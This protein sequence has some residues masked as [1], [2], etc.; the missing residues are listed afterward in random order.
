LVFKNIVT[1]LLIIGF[2]AGCA[3]NT[4]L[5]KK[6]NSI[7]LWYL[8]TPIN[9]SQFIYGTGTALTIDDAKANG[10]NDM[11]SRLVVSVGSTISSITKTSQDNSSSSYSKNVSKNIKVDIEKIKFSNAITE[12]NEY[13]QNNFYVLMKVDREE[14][15]SN[16]IKEFNVNDHRIETKITSLKK[17]AKLEQITILQTIY[18]IIIKAK[19]EAIILNAIKNSFNQAPYIKKYDSYIDMIDELKNNSKIM[20]KTNDK[21]KYFSDVLVDMLNQ[22]QFKVSNNSQSDIIIS[23][24]N[25]IKYSIARGWNIAKVSTTI[26]VISNSK[27]ISNKIITTI[28]RSSTSKE[29]ALE[30]A[31]VDFAKQLQKQTLDK[32]IFQK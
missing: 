5:E 7:P 24:N 28:G 23:L 4:L 31:S 16:K 10:L 2:I 25:K 29:S 14:L 9:N 26:S 3:Q 11:A 6:E 19:K 21:K 18:P 27:I 20:V 13:I 12:K 17:Y 1:L 32:I 22:K 15:F 8:N 30:N